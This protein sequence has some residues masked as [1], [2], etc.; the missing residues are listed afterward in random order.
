MKAWK[1]AYDHLT[2]EAAETILIEK[3]LLKPMASAAA[4]VSARRTELIS[5]ECDRLVGFMSDTNPLVL[6]PHLFKNHNYQA[7][8]PAAPTTPKPT[9]PKPTAPKPARKPG[10]PAGNKFK[11][12][13]KPIVKKQVPMVERLYRG[14][15]YMVPTNYRGSVLTRH[16]K[17]LARKGKGKGKAK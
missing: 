9:A 17:G 5:R 6:S 1:K 2:Y 14:K 11:P 7:P 12:K 13:P 3:G 16:L 8:K 4:L 15:T 10:R